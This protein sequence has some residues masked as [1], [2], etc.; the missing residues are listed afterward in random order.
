MGGL[1]RS[2]Y[3]TSTTASARP[4]WGGRDRDDAGSAPLLAASSS[5]SLQKPDGWM[6]WLPAGAV[7]AGTSTIP[8]Q[9]GPVCR[10]MAS[11]AV[12]IF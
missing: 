2:T 9:L 11:A 6:A 10:P 8:F 3:A 1:W 12:G 7:V 4:S 5:A